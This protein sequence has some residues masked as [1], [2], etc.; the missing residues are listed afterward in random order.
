[1]EERIK[2]LESRIVGVGP[3]GWHRAD[4]DLYAQIMDERNNRIKARLD[5]IE[6]AQANVCQ[7]VQVC[8]G[9]KP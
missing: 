7:R 8:K 1:M 6:A 3:A 5:I 2:A 4:H 9:S